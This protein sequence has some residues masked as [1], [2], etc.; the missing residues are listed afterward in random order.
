VE[1]G[2]VERERHLLHEEAVALVDG[3]GR[4]ARVGR[5]PV[6]RA[7]HSRDIVAAA[8]LARIDTVRT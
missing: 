8:E 5:R 2:D 6:T 1:P 4:L 7:G 3:C